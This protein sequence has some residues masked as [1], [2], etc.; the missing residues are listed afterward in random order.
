MKNL[1]K[2]GTTVMYHENSL[3]IIDGNDKE[4]TDE[5]E[6]VNYYVCPIECTNKK[7]WANDYVMLRRSEFIIIEE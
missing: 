7:Y 6:N 4:D 2:D 1:I 5:F 3:G